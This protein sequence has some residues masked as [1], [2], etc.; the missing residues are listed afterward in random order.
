MIAFKHQIFFSG[1]FC[2]VNFFTAKIIENRWSYLFI[3]SV[4][5]HFQIKLNTHGS[6]VNFIF[7]NLSELKF[8]LLTGVLT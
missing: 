4:A 6:N 1:V 2:I 7:V 5:S 3:G 8:F